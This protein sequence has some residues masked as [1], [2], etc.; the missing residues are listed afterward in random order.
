[1]QE[2]LEARI[3]EPVAPVAAEDLKRVMSLLESAQRESHQESAAVGVSQDLLRDLCSKDADVIA[4]W[5]RATL[6]GILRLQGEFTLDDR[7]YEVVAR[8]P[9]TNGLKGVNLEALLA[10]V[11]QPE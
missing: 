5:L 2:H 7:A 10:A 9:L 1:M 11:Q 6:V 8:F 4:V 3:G